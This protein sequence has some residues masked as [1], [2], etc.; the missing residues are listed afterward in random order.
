MKDSDDYGVDGPFALAESDGLEEAMIAPQKSV[1][2]PWVVGE[3]KRLPLLT[4]EQVRG[5]VPRIA[6]GDQ[7]ARDTLVM[8]NIGLVWSIAKRFWW[9]GLAI[10]DL[11]QEGICGLIKA[12][13]KFDL[14]H[15]TLFSTYATWWIRAAIGRAVCETS[16]LIRIPTHVQ[17]L[18]HRFIVCQAD[19]L[20]SGVMP[21]KEMLADKLGVPVKAINKIQS[22]LSMNSRQLSLDDAVPG[23]QGDAVVGDFVPDKSIPGPMVVLQAKQE[24]FGIRTRVDQIL[25][26]IRSRCGERDRNVFLWFYGFDAD[27]ERRTLEE[28]GQHFGITRERTRQILVRIWKCCGGD[29]V[30]QELE[31]LFASISV[32][33]ELAQSRLVWE[34]NNN[35]E[36]DQQF[37]LMFES[38]AKQVLTETEFA[39]CACH[40]GFDSA[41]CLRAEME[42]ATLL[43]I[44]IEQVNRTLSRLWIGLQPYARHLT[45]KKVRYAIESLNMVEQ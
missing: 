25:T 10:D 18:V 44:E 38:T 28:T 35:N 40:Y 27:L 8:H 37:L 17:E 43:G 31:Q 30:K 33:E 29:E 36:R 4:P 11:V 5:L 14:A 45:R 16:Q 2:I 23:Y 42:T 7:C 9:S 32:L 15:G 1:A 19:L 39:I 21:T 41:Y 13:E 24:L 12:V 20:E 26:L 3:R 22:I 34:N 6:T